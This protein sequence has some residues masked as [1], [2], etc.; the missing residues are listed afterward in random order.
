M[1]FVA[2]QLFNG[3]KFGVLTLVNKFSRQCLVTR[4]GQSIKG[5]DVL[6]IMNE[7]KQYLDLTQEIIHVD[8]RPEFISKDFDK[9][10]YKNNVILDFSRP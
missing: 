9:W 3:R 10:V 2:D 1:D 4:V 5:I 8:N 6:R 7:V